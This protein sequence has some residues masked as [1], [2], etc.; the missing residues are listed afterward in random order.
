MVIPISPNTST[1]GG[2]SCAR[3][4]VL[5][6]WRSCS[7]SICCLQSERGDAD[8]QRAR[9]LEPAEQWQDEEEMEE[10]VCGAQSTQDQP[11][12]LRWAASG[13]GEQHAIR[14]SQKN[15]RKIDLKRADR[16]GLV[17]SQGRAK[18]MKIAP[19]IASRRP[20]ACSVSHEEW[21]NG[22]ASTIRGRCAMA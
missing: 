13:E 8:W 11:C 20:G 14:D 12:S 3:T 10:I 1:P 7:L 4:D 5:W 17:S 21:R 22:V 2:N 16:T 15:G 19:N 9:S 18:R 6:A